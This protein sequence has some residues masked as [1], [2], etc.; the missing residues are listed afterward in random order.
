M[1]HSLDAV[2]FDTLKKK[3]KKHKKENKHK[4]SIVESEAAISDPLGQA[5]A[6]DPKQQDVMDE[7]KK[8]KKKKHKSE[9]AVTGP[10]ANGDLALSTPDASLPPPEKKSKKRKRE[11]EGTEI[12]KGMAEVEIEK[13]VKKKRAS[14]G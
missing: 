5:T 8:K 12:A 13:K 10:E 6:G 3:S 14:I 9:M 4:K 1:S 7:G 2:D 11:T